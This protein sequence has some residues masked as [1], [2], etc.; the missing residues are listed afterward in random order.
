[1]KRVVSGL[2]SSYRYEDDKLRYRYAIF[3]VT[4]NEHYQSQGISYFTYSE[5]VRFLVEVRGACWVEAGIGVASVHYQWNPLI[6]S[7]LEI[8][9]SVDDKCDEIIKILGVTG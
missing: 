2:S 1:M 8:D 7:I 9:R 4:A 5:L 3:A 6:N